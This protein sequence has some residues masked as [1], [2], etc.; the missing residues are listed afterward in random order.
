MVV[1]TLSSLRDIRKLGMPSPT[2]DPNRMFA[3]PVA[4]VLGLAGKTTSRGELS[5]RWRLGSKEEGF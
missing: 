5:V 3:T 2:R 1:S 4:S